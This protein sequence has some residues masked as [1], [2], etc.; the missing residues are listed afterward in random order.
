MHEYQQIMEAKEY[1]LSKTTVVA[2]TAIILG[3]GLGTLAQKVQDASVLSYRD[4]PHFCSSEVEGHANRLFIGMLNGKQIVL[5]QGRFHFYEGYTLDEITFPIR[6]FQALGIQNLIVTN[7][8]G[9]VNETFKPGD[10][11]L[12]EDHI[13]MVG[14]NPLIGKNDE[15]LGVRFPDASHVYTRKLR[16]LAQRVAKDMNIPLQKGVYCWTSGPIFETPAE[17]KMYRMMGASAVGMSTV[18]ETIVACHS[19]MNVLGISCISNMAA[20]VLEQPLSMQEVLD[21]TEHIKEI[22]VSLVE[23]IVEEIETEK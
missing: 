7:A 19:G 3:S 16:E 13:N 10:L 23:R 9:G 22:F 1:I 15:R 11:M 14:V 5:M 6:V 21:T 4:I 12:I 8:A 17:I 18:P 2:D 20:G